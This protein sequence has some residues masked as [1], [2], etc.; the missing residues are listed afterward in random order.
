MGTGEKRPLADRSSSWIFYYDGNCG[1]CGW[2]V[3]WLSRLDL[4][5]GVDWVPFQSLKTPPE[6]LSWEDLDQAAYL[7]V[8][9]RKLLP[10]FYAFR[11][12]TLKVAFLW[13]LAPIFWFP[14]VQVPGVAVYRW[15]A[16]NRYRL[17]RCAT[18]GGEA[19]Q[20]RR[21]GSRPRDD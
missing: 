4:G 18:P 19:E 20:H 11:R 3:N 15:V 2:L 12:L 7:D 10:G 21:S 1:L 13:P 16:Q 14:G 6:S 17:S 8:G 5:R 9:G